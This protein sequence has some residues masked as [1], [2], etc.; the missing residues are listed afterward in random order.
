MNQPTTFSGA[1]SSEALL[2]LQFLEVTRDIPP[3]TL[4]KN[5]LTS[6]HGGNVSR[7]AD[8]PDGIE[9]RRRAQLRA[10]WSTVWVLTVHRFG[11]NGVMEDARKRTSRFD[12]EDYRRTRDTGERAWLWHDG[13]RISLANGALQRGD[14]VVRL[15]PRGDSELEAE[16]WRIESVDTQSMKGTCL[17]GWTIPEVEIGRPVNVPLLADRLRDHL[18]GIR[19]GRASGA[20]LR[21]MANCPLTA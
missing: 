16:L 14:A 12:W 19:N 9:E 4:A 1:A 13:N 10:L 8:A 5:P 20:G 2:V 15:L 6:F 18:P 7:S 21:P 17:H 11:V 3:E